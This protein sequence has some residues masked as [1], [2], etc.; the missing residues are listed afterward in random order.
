MDL[1]TVLETGLSIAISE[2]KKQGESVQHQK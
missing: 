2:T 1:I